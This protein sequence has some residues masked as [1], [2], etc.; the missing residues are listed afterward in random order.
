MQDD[1]PALLCMP[2][3]E[4]LGITRVMCETIGNK[5]TSKKLDLQAKHVVGSQNCKT[6]KDL[7]AM[8][9]KCSPP[10]DKP[11]YQTI[12]IPAESK[13]ID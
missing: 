2:D 5:T 11:T 4:L 9:D 1:F 7:Q 13:L 12:L 3:T 8:Q 6:N 10:I